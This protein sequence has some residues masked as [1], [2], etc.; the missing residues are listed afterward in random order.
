MYDAL[1]S[2][3]PYKQPYTHEQAVDIIK[4]DSGVHFDPLIVEAFLN[5]ADD[6]WVESLTR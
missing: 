3:R 4:K 2:E 6:F 1:V 5:I